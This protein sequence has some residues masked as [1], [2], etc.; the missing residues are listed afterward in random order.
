MRPTNPTTPLNPPGASGMAPLR[1][2]VVGAECTGK[3]TLCRE[4]TARLGG[5]WVPEALREFVDARDRAPAAH[6]QP[7]L[8]AEQIARELAALAEAKH[9]GHPLLAF[10]SAPLATALYSQLYFDDHALVAA[11]IA[12]HHHY[13]LTLLT[14]TDLPWEPDGLQRDGPVMRSRFHAL[15]TASLAQA[16]LAV[17]RIA[18]SDGARLAAAH[19]A[20]AAARAARSLAK[21]DPGADLGTDFT[22]VPGRAR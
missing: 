12:H 8:M 11:A 6:E 22:A 10:D 17:T 5:L 14:D 3:T 2:A 1:I 9:H 19:D 4:I 7:A 15:L 16:G 18:G 13:D 21:A 20:I